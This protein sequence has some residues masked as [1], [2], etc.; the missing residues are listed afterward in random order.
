VILLV[1]GK[2]SIATII[3]AYDEGRL[4]FRDP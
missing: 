4:S 1:N 3:R 2:G